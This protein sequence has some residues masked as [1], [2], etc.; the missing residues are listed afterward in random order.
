MC[1]IPSGNELLLQK[2][3]LSPGMKL[4]SPVLPLQLAAVPSPPPQP[5]LQTNR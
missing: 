4:H 2:V 1:V 3:E 5:W